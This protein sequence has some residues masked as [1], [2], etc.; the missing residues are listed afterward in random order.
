MTARLYLYDDTRART[1]EPFTATRP[2]SELRAGALLV[3]ERWEYAAGMKAT[4]FV[5]APHLADFEEAEA[6]AP[7][8]VTDETVLPEGSL[9]VNAR[10]AIALD[11]VLAG[12]PVSQP[13]TKSIGC[14]INRLK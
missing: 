1:F 9:V 4:G 5:S 7:P 14:A 12:K 11:E 10:C 2:A 6:G 8:F 3:R 13:F